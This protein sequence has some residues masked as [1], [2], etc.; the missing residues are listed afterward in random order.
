MS[1]TSDDFRCEILRSPTEGHGNFILLD[2]LGHSEISQ[3]GIADIIHEDVFRFQVP[4]NNVFGM[5]VSQSQQDFRGIE[6]GP[7]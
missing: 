6:F 1:L 3:T 4:V 5:Q 2:D 7:F